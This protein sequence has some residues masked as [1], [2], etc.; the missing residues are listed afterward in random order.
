MK[1]AEGGIRLLYA[2]EVLVFLR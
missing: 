2:S 1:S